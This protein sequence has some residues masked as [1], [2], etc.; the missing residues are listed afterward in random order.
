MKRNTYC[1]PWY[2]RFVMCNRFNI[3]GVGGGEKGRNM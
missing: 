2:D 3:Y 1:G